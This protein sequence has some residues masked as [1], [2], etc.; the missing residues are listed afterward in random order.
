MVKAKPGKLF[1]KNAYFLECFQTICKK[2]VGLIKK[3]IQN[4]QQ[5][6]SARSI[7]LVGGFFESEVVKYRFSEQNIKILFDGGLVVFKGETSYRFD[8]SINHEPS[9]IDAL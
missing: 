7:I 1:F 3:I 6:N 9:E 4:E 2:T 5:G 8:S